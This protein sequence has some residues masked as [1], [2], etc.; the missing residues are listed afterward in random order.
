MTELFLNQR[1]KK[2]TESSQG[3]ENMAL[4]WRQRAIGLPWS[5]REHRVVLKYSSYREDSGHLDLFKSKR[6]LRWVTDRERLSCPEV[7]EN[8]SCLEGKEKLSCPEVKEKTEV[9]LSYSSQEER[10]SRL[11]SWSL[12]EDWIVLQSKKTLFIVLEPMRRS[13]LLEVKK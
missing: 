1:V 12:R 9:A 3:I 7:E 11:M 8:L 10:L 2:K 6:R 5:Q 4:F 13:H